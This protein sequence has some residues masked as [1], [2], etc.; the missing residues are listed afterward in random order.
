MPLLA[1][2]EDAPGNRRVDYAGLDLDWRLA[3]GDLEIAPGITAVATY[4]HTPGHQSF[5]VDLDD[6]G[7]FVFAFDAADLQ[8]NIDEELSVGGLIDAEIPRRLDRR[9]PPVEGARGR[10][11][12]PAVTRPRPRRVARVR[13]RVGIAAASRGR[14]ALMVTGRDHASCRGGAGRDRRA[15]PARV[16]RADVVVGTGRPDRRPL[17]PPGSVRRRRASRS[18]TPAGCS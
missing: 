9:D 13:R 14:P 15:A 3:D 12:L 4:G 11:G 18:S 6:G 17:A 5:M 1:G 2:E 10:E 16:E 8:R 7:G